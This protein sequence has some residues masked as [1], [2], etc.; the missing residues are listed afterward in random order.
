MAPGNHERPRTR[1]ARHARDGLE[2]G[3][4]G[5]AWIAVGMLGDTLARS[6][7]PGFG[8]KGQDG[9]IPDAEGPRA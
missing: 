1:R 9:I 6:P 4:S 5:Y 3:P 7:I 2:R 8:T